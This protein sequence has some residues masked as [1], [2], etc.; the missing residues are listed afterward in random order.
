MFEPLSGEALRHAVHNRPPARIAL[1]E[2]LLY[3]RTATMI[4]ADPGAGKSTVITQIMLQLT[5]AQPVFG[6]FYTPQPRNV[7]YLQLEGDPDETLER[8]DFMGR[9]LT[10][11]YERFRL[12]CPIFLDCLDE[13]SI[14]ETIQRINTWDKVPDVIVIDPI[15]MA[16]SGDLK[17]GQVSSALV[18][19]SERLKRTFRC[20]VVLVHHTHRERY[21]NSGERIS[22][23]D[24][25][26][27]SQWLKA[28]IDVGYHLRALDGHTGVELICKK[29]RGGE[30]QKHI[31]LAY[32]PATF[33]VRTDVEQSSMSGEARVIHHLRRC[34]G[35]NIQ[36]DFYATLAETH[37]SQ[38]SLRRIQRRLEDNGTIQ[39]VAGEGRR[40]LWR[41]MEPMASQSQSAVS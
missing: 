26:Y 25:Y 20:A 3:E 27:G 7:Y 32:D 16:V 15:Y 36:T 5:A 31:S 11:D 39:V 40:R 2:E 8:I 33:T 34:A 29:S 30:V 28:H 9:T 4:A 23:N 17:D 24:P 6:F 1:T 35:Q 10:I 19:F 14:L 21:G 38:A 22:E 12:D 37:L 41:L 18:H 13:L